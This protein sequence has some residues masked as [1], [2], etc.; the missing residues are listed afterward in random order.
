MLPLAKGPVGPLSKIIPMPVW[1]PLGVNAV[2]VCAPML[3]TVAPEI[4]TVIV[5]SPESTKMP[6]W[7]ASWTVND[8]TDMLLTM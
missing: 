6:Y 2:P 7:F 5:P 8:E 4:E 3:E 1:T